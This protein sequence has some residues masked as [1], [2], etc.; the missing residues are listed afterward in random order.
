MTATF[1]VSVGTL[2][3]KKNVCGNKKI[4]QDCL[5]DFWEEIGSGDGKGV[6]VFGVKAAKGFR[7]LYVGRT[8]KQNF[9]IFVRMP[10]TRSGAAVSPKLT[11]YQ[12][13]EAIKR[14]DRDGETLAEIRRS[15][16][17]SGWTAAE[18]PINFMQRQ[19]RHSA[20]GVEQ[21]HSF[22][23]LL[24]LECGYVQH[25]QVLKRRFA[26]ITPS[27]LLLIRMPPAQ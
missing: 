13:R 17:V 1:K 14:R 3:C 4:D 21:G 27:R 9:E 10:F 11:D 15:Y 8:K 22:G 24:W 16:N 2:K 6:Y 5:D 18:V 19:K 25:G 7:P 20:H 12:K 26:N 23:Q